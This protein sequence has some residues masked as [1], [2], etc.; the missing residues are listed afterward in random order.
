MAK[1]GKWEVESDIASVTCQG[2][3]DHSMMS[4]SRWEQTMPNWLGPLFA[5]VVLAGFT[6]FAFRR[7]TKV[8]PDKDN[9]D[10]W[11]SSGGGQS[12]GDGSHHGGFDG[13]SGH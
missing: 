8:T 13:H 9:P 1:L 6:G 2:L 5:L 4:V 3:Q 12:T 10:N 7:G 11:S